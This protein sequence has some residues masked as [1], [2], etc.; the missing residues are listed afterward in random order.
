M[1]KNPKQMT[2]KETPFALLFFILPLS[3]W[4]QGATT[5]QLQ[6]TAND[7]VILSTKDKHNAL[8]D[9]YI[10]YNKARGDYRIQIISGPLDKVQETLDNLEESFKNLEHSIDFE[11]P[12]FRLRIG[13]FKT[14][15]EAERNL[16]TI[17]KKYPAAVLLKPQLKQQQ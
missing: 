6:E 14:R 16:I 5:E 13:S 15:L 9:A 4:A 17:R 2:L 1:L 3:L 7:T 11:S 12:S 8:L 10:N